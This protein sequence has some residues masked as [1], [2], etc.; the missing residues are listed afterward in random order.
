M[1]QCGRDHTADGSFLGEKGAREG[2]E[3]VAGTEGA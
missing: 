3:A 2:P 1:K